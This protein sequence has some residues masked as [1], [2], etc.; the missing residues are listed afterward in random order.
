L[1]GNSRAG[2]F[3]VLKQQAP[4]E[5]TINGVTEKFYWGNAAHRDW[6]WQNIDKPW[7]DKAVER[8]DK[9]YLTDDPESSS[10]MFTRLP[11]GQYDFTMYFREVDYMVSKG[12]TIGN[13]GQLIRPQ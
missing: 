8:G 10:N 13:G 1:E 12:Y 6:Y 2:G 3:N 11:N 7:S 9:F 5:I 4:K